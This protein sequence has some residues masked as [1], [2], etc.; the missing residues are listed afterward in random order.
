MRVITHL[1]WINSHREQAQKPHIAIDGKVLRGCWKGDVY[2]AL[3]V[4]SAFDVDN[5]LALYQQTAK[6]KGDFIIQ[7]KANQRNL[8]N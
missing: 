2:N 7:V 1:D 5:G 4:V 3:N 6:N 8:H